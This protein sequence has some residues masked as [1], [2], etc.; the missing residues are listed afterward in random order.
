MCL[1]FFF[2]LA[3]L[4][5]PTLDLISTHR[6]GVFGITALEIPVTD[7]RFS[8][9]LVSVCIPFFLLI[10]VL[11]THAAMN[12]VRKCGLFVETCF[13]RLLGPPPDH[14]RQQHRSRSH[15][16]ASTGGGGGGGAGSGGRNGS[17]AAVGG[18]G[19]GGGGGGRAGHGVGAADAERGVRHRWRKRLRM[20]RAARRESAAG[21]QMHQQ[22]SRRGSREKVGWSRL[23]T[24]RW[25]WRRRD[26]G[27]RA[28]QNDYNV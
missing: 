28:A 12:A 11:Q 15:S 16:R 13:Q 23:R 8:V 1:L 3:F 19:G 24:W 5:F 21:L 10:L 7:W 6:Q 18:G 9:T 27:A 4:F 20:A 25:P 14:R 17:A 22:K 2:L 26:E